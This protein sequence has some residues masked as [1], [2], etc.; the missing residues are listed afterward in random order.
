MKTISKYKIFDNTLTIIIHEL[1]TDEY[2]AF[3]TALE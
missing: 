2:N 1:K 3:D